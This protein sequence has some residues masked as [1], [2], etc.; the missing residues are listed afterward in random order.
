MLCYMWW[1]AIYFGDT[2]DPR[3]AQEFSAALIEAMGR[4]LAIPHP[5]CQ[6]GALHGLG[7]W[8]SHAPARAEALINAY[9]TQNRASRPE[10]VNYALAARSGCIQ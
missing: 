7:H 3:L 8:G 6:E 1:D 10:L 2:G 9:L 4:T 5:A